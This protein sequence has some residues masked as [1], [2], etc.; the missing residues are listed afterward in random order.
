MLVGTTIVGAA[1]VG[2]SLTYGEV[3]GVV[4]VVLAGAEL[5]D[6]FV[7]EEVGLGS[8][9]GFTRI[10]S[11]SDSDS[12]AAYIAARSTSSSSESLSRSAY[13]NLCTLVSRTTS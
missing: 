9:V 13:T 5:L 11:S 7:P 6:V 1:G 4:V 12:T 3:A 10:S 2:V 8:N